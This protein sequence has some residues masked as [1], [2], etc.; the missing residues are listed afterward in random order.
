MCELAVADETGFLGVLYG[1]LVGGRPACD[2]RPRRGLP[3]APPSRV[4]PRSEPAR[5]D[6]RREDRDRQHRATVPRTNDVGGRRVA[7]ELELLA[8]RWPEQLASGHELE[9]HVAEFDE[10]SR[11]DDATPELGAVDA[12]A[13]ARPVVDDLEASLAEGTHVAVHARN[14]V[15]IDGDRRLFG[16]PDRQKLPVHRKLGPWRR[17]HDHDESVR[18]IEGGGRNARVGCAGNGD[19][20]LVGSRL[21][22][23]RRGRRRRG[24]GLDLV[25][26]D[27]PVVPDLDEVA[28]R[29]ILGVGNAEA[30]DEDAVIARQIF[31]NE[32][33]S[34]RR[35]RRF[36]SIS[37]HGHARRCARS[38]GSYFRPCDRLYRAPA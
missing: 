19:L 24:V 5:H 7:Q 8:V 27:D 34:S 13:V 17:P 14:G 35:A 3:L 22:S 1:R 29:Q 6:H 21:R 38:G 25:L 32:G 28:L 15:V 4:H 30:V 18:A 26:K 11:L 2:G 9:A 33:G 20:C 10:V 12:N 23:A 16:A 37:W 31:E 36:A